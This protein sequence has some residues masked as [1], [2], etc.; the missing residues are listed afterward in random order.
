MGCLKSEMERLLRNFLARF[1]KVSYIKENNADLTQLPCCSDEAQLLD[2][3]A[4]GMSARSYL[5]KKGKT[6]LLLLHQDFSYKQ[7]YIC[8]HI[9]SLKCND[10]Q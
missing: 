4:V 6:F 2:L 7:F 5:D 10:C 8:M 1:I 3:I 9:P